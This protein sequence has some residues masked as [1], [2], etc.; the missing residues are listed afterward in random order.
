[1]KC[2]E[3]DVRMSRLFFFVA[4]VAFLMA[5]TVLATDSQNQQRPSIDQLDVPPDSYLVL[6]LNKGDL[7][8]K[9]YPKPVPVESRRA[10]HPD[11]YYHY[12]T[13]RDV[14]ERLD[15][16]LM[17]DAAMFAKICRTV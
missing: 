15:G 14:P 6:R 16:I 10:R 9:P 5:L 12:R 11:T 4:A 1:M 7:I 8:E 2:K 3:S 17:D 13:R